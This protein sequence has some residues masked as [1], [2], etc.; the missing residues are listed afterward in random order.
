MNE[1]QFEM[2]TINGSLEEAAAQVL[3]PSTRALW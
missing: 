3:L 2:A 1:M